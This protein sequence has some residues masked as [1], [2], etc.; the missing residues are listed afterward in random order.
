MELKK[1][2]EGLLLINSLYIY[3]YY[4]SKK[5]GFDFSIV[6]YVVYM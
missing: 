3:N 6:T 4:F 2:L 5:K 1:E